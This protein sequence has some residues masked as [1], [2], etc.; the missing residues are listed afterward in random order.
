MHVCMCTCISFSTTGRS[1]KLDVCVCVHTTALGAGGWKVYCVYA[2]M[3][4]YFF[5]YAYVCIYL[6]YE[7]VGVYTCVCL[8]MCKCVSIHSYRRTSRAE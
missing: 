6:F 8:H 7:C 5:A 4:K 2:C 3:C 1:F